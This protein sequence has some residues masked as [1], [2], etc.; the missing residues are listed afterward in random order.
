MPA[1]YKAWQRDFIKLFPWQRSRQPLR[2]P[3]EVFLTF[4]CAVPKSY[5]KTERA[6]ALSGLVPC[7]VGDADN[8]A[9][10]VLDALTEVGLWQDDKQVDRL[11]VVKAYGECDGIQIGVRL[12]CSSSPLAHPCAEGAPQR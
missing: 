2:G 6:A 12:L 11:T 8:L 10:S 9:K 3:L 4:T 1:A 5:T 7:K